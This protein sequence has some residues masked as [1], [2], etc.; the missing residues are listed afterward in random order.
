MPSP[1]R[2]TASRHAL[3][4]E[5][6]QLR[7]LV[8][9][10]GIELDKNYAQM[11]LMEREGTN[12]RQQLYAKNKRKRTY[13]TGKAR[14]MTGE[15]MAQA[16]LDDLQKKLMSDLHSEMKKKKFP[17][18]KKALAQAEKDAKAAAKAAEKAA[19]AATRG[20]GR[21]RGRGGRVRGGRGGGAARGRGRGRGRPHDNDWDS[22]DEE[23][24]PEPESQSSDE[25]RDPVEGVVTPDPGASATNPRF[26]AET[27]SDGEDGSDEEETAIESFNGHRWESRRNL[28]FQV[29]WTD[30][31]VTWEPL[32]NVNDCAAM[33]EYLAHHDLDD[34]LL[35][36][37]RKSLIKVGLKAINE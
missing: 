16:L 4:A 19:N 6:E 33:E 34:P 30:G 24:E 5:N 9:A 37:K 32:S 23:S 29:V 8:K 18:I 1:V 10:A 3:A 21:G 35:L 31:D 13:T 20:R 7:T 22:G 28:E 25:E 14:L 15:E 17:E 2:K 26:A 12:M 36:S 27:E 11:M